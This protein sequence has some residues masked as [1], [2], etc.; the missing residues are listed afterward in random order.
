MF[1][2][3]VSM[4]R[5]GL[6]C[7]GARSG[8]IGWLNKSGGYMRSC[9]GAGENKRCALCRCRT[10][11]ISP[12]H[13]RLLAS[14][15]HYTRRP[16]HLFSSSLAHLSPPLWKHLKTRTRSR[17]SRSVYN[18]SLI[19]PLHASMSRVYPPLKLVHIP[20]DWHPRLFHRPGG[21][22]SR[23]LV[24]TDSHK[25][26]RTSSVA[27]ETIGCILGRMPRSWCV[28]GAEFM[29]TLNPCAHRPFLHRC[30]LRTR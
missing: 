24:P 17:A 6:N 18:P 26:T 1:S 13:H 9:G 28:L 10:A 23:P 27:G 20:R 16:T 15:L 2:G 21:T 5:L 7:R 4:V 19:A 29:F 30:R 14:A 8:L 12:I 22:P 11:P 3:L 25:R